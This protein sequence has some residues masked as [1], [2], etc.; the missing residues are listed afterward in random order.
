MQRLAGFL[1]REVARSGV[2]VVVVEVPDHRRPC[3]VEHPLD[4]AGGDVLVLA[5]GLE[6]GALGVVLH[7][8]RDALVVGGGIAAA[9]RPPPWLRRRPS[10]SRTRRRHC[11]GSSRPWA[12]T[13]ADR[14]ETSRGWRAEG[15][16]GPGTGL[17][18]EAEGA[19]V[20]LV[21]IP[22]ARRDIIVRARSSSRR[23]RR[24][25]WSALRMPKR[26]SD[27]ASAFPTSTLRY[28]LSTS[29]GG[30]LSLPLSQTSR[31]AWWRRRSICERKRGRGD[32]QIVGLSSLP[33]LPVVAAAPAKHDQ[34]ALLIGEMEELIG[35]ELAFEANGVEVHVAHHAGTDRAS[36]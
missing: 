6:H 27:W 31:L 29:A 17:G 5:V 12:A 35:F 8:L 33:V 26:G 16:A 24:S 34:D 9:R 14:A 11:A 20:V 3:V 1:G 25:P 30:G 32:G 23:S 2:E 7:G 15:I 21:D 22:I 28:A 4:D 18:V 36:R 10:D 13:P 19:A